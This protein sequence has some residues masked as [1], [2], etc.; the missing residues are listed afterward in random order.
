MPAVNV[1]D[2]LVIIDKKLFR[3]DNTLVFVCVVEEYEEQTIRARGFSYHINPY[4]VAGTE[5]A[6]EERVRVVPMSG[7]SVCYV[8]PEEIEIE[9]LQLKRSPKMIVL[10]DGTMTLDLSESMLRS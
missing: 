4:E 9:R 5:R 6:S 3:D 10:T 7:T 1:G 2:K 8:L